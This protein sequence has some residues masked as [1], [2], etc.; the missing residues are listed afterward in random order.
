M[1]EIPKD[2]TEPPQK[3]I[4]TLDPRTEDGARKLL[5]PYLAGL[6]GAMEDGWKAWVELGD[7]LPS[8]RLPLRSRTRANFVYD[9]IA[10]NAVARFGKDPKVRISESRGFLQLLIDRKYILRFKKLDRKRRSRNISTGQQRLWFNVQMSLP[11]MPAEA[12]RLIAGYQ[13][14]PFGT[15]FEDILV[16]RPANGRIDWAFSIPDSSAE[17]GVVVQIRPVE[18]KLPE[19]RSKIEKSKTDSPDEPEKE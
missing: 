17:G 4:P 9:H 8:A 3:K 7:K 1:S 5:A 15:E 16:T 2:P 18:P 12:V 6:R 19:I 14:N 13:L 10:A 11:E